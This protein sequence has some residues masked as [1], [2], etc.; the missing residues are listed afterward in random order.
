M[1][2][3]NTSQNFSAKTLVQTRLCDAKTL[4]VG[5]KDIV[6]VNGGEMLQS[7]KVQS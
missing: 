6:M 5:C 1:D 2:A 7:L 4:F 3:G